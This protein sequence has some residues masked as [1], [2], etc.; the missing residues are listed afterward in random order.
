MWGHYTDNQRGMIIKFTPDAAFL[1]EIKTIQYHP[2]RKA[3]NAY[4]TPKETWEH[5]SDIASI[6][7]HKSD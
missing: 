4:I 1:Q 7:Y 3:M 6:L 5:I 2:E